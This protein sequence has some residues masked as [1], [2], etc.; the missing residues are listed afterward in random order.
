VRLWA[1]ADGQLQRTLEGHT[2]N[3]WSLAFSP[4][5]QRLASGSF[6]KTIVLWDPS[7]GQNVSTLQGHTNFVRS[8]A[9]TPSGARLLSGGDDGTVRVWD[10]EADQLLHTA[11]SLTGVNNPFFRFEADGT[12]TIANHRNAGFD[13]QVWRMPLP[14]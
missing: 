4:N 14:A 13:V 1:A 12:A 5:G 7:T 11:T 10:V 8:V 3:V 2:S 9:F 6:D